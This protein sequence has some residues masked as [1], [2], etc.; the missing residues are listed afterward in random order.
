[1]LWPV[2]RWRLGIPSVDFWSSQSVQASVHFSS[3]LASSGSPHCLLGRSANSP[4]GNWGDHRFTSFVFSL[5]GVT[6]L[7]CL[8][9]SIWKPLFHVFFCFNCWSWESKCNPC[10]SI[11]ARCVHSWNMKLLTHILLC[12][13]PKMWLI[14]LYL[15]FIF[16]FTS[17]WSKHFHAHTFLLL[18]NYFLKFP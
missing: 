4:G 6:V 11:L 14:P 16:I 18:L 10:N 8:S 5:L 12:Y 15:T 3:T 7:C 13:Y 1:M 9:S 2:V 17:C